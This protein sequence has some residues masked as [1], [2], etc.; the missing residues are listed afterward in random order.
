ML[1]IKEGV[2]LQWDGI[3][4]S[5][6]AMELSYVRRLEKFKLFKSL[7]IKLHFMPCTKAHKNVTQTHSITIQPPK[8]PFKQLDYFIFLIFIKT[9]IKASIFMLACSLMK[10]ISLFK[11][12]NSEKFIALHI[13]SLAWV[14][15]LNL[16]T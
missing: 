6:K 15:S 4:G 16:R 7:L 1:I 12:Q 11:K 14:E 3:E 10:F 5:D 9:N 8:N 2:G 13:K